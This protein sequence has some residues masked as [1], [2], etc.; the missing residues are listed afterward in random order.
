MWYLLRR[1][2]TNVSFLNSH[3]Y[4]IYLARRNKLI[5]NVKHWHGLHRQSP[6]FCFKT[7]T[8]LLSARNVSFCGQQCAPMHISE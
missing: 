7:V 4:P 2:F 3:F 6:L 1:W 5:N 8:E